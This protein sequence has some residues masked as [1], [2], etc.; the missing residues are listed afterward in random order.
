MVFTSLFFRF[1]QEGN[2]QDGTDKKGD[3]KYRYQHVIDN[4]IHRLPIPR[5]ST[6][7]QNSVQNDQPLYRT[8]TIFVNILNIA[9]WTYS[10]SNYS[11]SIL[12]PQRCNMKLIVCEC[13]GS[14][15]IT[16]NLEENLYSV[17]CPQCSSSTPEY[18]NFRDAQRM[19]N[20]WCWRLGYCVPEDAMA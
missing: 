7:I 1:K 2:N 13:G 4:C 8:T 20:N 19:W 18:S 11:I 12:K 15:Q 5:I 3:A 17:S 14:P 9:H 10:C 16:Q 6:R